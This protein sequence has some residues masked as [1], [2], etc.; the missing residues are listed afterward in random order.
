MSSF[1]RFFIALLKPIMLGLIV[2][3]ILLIFIP[4]FRHGSGLN[5]HWLQKEDNPPE[6]LSYYDAISRSAPAVVYIYGVSID[7]PNPNSIFRGRTTERTNLGSGV[8][9][10]EDGYLI[11]CYHVIKDT[12][13]IFIRL[14]D[15]RTLEAQ[16]VG[17]DVESDLAVLKVDAE[18]LHVMPQVRKPSLR[19]GDVVMAI[20]NPLDLG[21]TITQGI[22]S[23]ISRNNLANYFDFIQ[24]DAVL[25]P[26]NSGGA[27]VDSNGYLVGITNAN[28]KTRGPSGRGLTTV[29]GINFAV[30]YE[31]AKKVMEE[32][33]VSGTVVRG[34]LG[35]VGNA[36]VERKGMVVTQVTR[37][38]PADNAGLKVK[39]I[40]LAI[41]GFQIEENDAGH[42]LNIVSQ[43]VP[44]TELTLKIERN[45]EPITLTVIVGS[46][47]SS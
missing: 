31:L 9:M 42:A 13:T 21:Q 43:S 23:R 39:D 22:V 27:L 26:G 7:N 11:T 20:G 34:Q 44:G 41:N 38:G 35:F 46:S 10:K 5:V 18:D 28:F 30:P 15:S 3:A 47:A 36:L 19:V 32:I 4:E 16:I 29:D 8:V 12:D 17:F 2:A 37:G 45:E 40:L 25:H 6:R 24:T 1:Q 14:Q 33:I